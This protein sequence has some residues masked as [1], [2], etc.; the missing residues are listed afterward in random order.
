MGSKEATVVHLA[1]CLKKDVLDVDSSKDP[2]AER[3]VELLEQL[4][5]VDRVSIE[6]LEKS[7]IGKLLA[8]AK[9]SFKRYKRKSSQDELADWEKAVDLSDRILEKWKS[10]ADKEAKTAKTSQKKAQA[11]AFLEDDGSK[12]QFPSTVAEYRQRL[13]SQKKD[14]Y[15]D[16]PVLPPSGIAVHPIRCDTPK[17]DQKTGLLSFTA[18]D[19][20]V[21]TLLKDFRPNRTPEEVLRAGS[22]GGTYFRPIVSAVTNIHYRDAKKVLKDTVPDAWIDGLSMQ[23]LASTTYKAHINKYGVSCGGSLGMWESSGWI[24]ALDRE[25]AASTS[26]N[27]GGEIRLRSDFSCFDITVC[28]L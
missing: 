20:N 15:K 3:C 21:G 6:L 28:F 19:P 2:S 22:F 13:V 23:W 8:K 18:Q 14:M 25:Y 11:T 27:D 12:G 17:R 4:D 7:Q 24:S 16:P 1:G 26:S 9:K 10:A 5:M